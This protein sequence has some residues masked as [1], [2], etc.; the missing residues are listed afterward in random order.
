MAVPDSCQMPLLACFRLPWI[1]YEAFEMPLTDPD[2]GGDVRSTTHSLPGETKRPP[3]GALRKASFVEQV[4]RPCTPIPHPQPERLRLPSR[5]ILA[6]AEWAPMP[7]TVA[8][9]LPGWLARQRPKP[10]PAGAGMA[11]V[12]DSPFSGWLM[13]RKYAA[14]VTGGHELRRPN[15]DG[16]TDPNRCPLVFSLMP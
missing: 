5:G 14:S 3:D 7:P 4:R 6:G 2:A 16:C 1:L 11:S 15:G 8:P 12:S 9:A 10:T 13:N